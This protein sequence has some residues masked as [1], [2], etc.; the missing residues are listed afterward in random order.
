M[1]EEKERGKEGR[2]AENELDLSD[3]LISPLLLARP[4]PLS[5]Q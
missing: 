1:D 5:R 4:A 3:P 2:R